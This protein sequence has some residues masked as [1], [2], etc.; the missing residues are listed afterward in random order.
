MIVSKYVKGFIKVYQ[1]NPLRFDIEYCYKGDGYT[2]IQ[3]RDVDSGYSEGSWIYIKSGGYWYTS[4]K[5]GGV[6]VAENLA[7]CLT[8]REIDYIYDV[9]NTYKTIASGQMK[10]RVLELTLG[11]YVNG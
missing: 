11:R 4:C 6:T 7:N 9:V 8:D 5:V 1:E 3:I 2:H 10:E